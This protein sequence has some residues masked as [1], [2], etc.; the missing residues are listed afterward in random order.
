MLR[1]YETID[2]NGPPLPSG[3]SFAN[4][5]TGN[6]H[7]PNLVVVVIADQQN[8]V[9]V[10]AQP[11]RLVQACRRGRA[12]VA[13]IAGMRAARHRFQ[14]AVAGDPPHAVV[15]RV[16]EVDRAVR[17]DRQAVGQVQPG[18]ARGRAVG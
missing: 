4:S 5:T 1:P 8:I 10:E 11:V 7:G 6:V 3:E 9:A 15:A 2:I 17:A 12:A 14:C 18:L 16:G 13:R